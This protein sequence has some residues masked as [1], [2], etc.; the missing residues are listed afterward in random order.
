[1]VDSYDLKTF[2]SIIYDL[3]KIASGLQTAA[4]EENRETILLFY[5]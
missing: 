2:I 1:M 3:F 4:A 5:P